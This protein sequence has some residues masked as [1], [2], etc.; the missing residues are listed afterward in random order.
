MHSVTVSEFGGNLTRRKLTWT[1]PDRR[2]AGRRTERPDSHGHGYSG[3][4]A[5]T[6][7]AGDHDHDDHGHRRD[8]DPGVH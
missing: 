1:L 5:L 2:L 3:C 4:R 8:R 7:T 6:L